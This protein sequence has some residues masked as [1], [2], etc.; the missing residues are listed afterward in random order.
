MFPVRIKSKNIMGIWAGA[1]SLP[2]QVGETTGSLVTP[3]LSEGKVQM[4]WVP[5]GI[6]AIN[7]IF[8]FNISN[9]FGFSGCL[10]RTIRTFE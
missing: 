1:C 6:V 10:I 9:E 4:M 5:L 7:H 3:G 8:D 2:V